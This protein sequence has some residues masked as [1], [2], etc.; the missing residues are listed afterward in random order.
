MTSRV[1][2]ASP[3]HDLAGSG[4]ALKAAFDAAPDW[5]ARAICRAQTYLRYPTDIVWRPHGGSQRREIA[6][7][8]HSADVVQAMNHPR[9]LAWFRPAQSQ[10]LV[11]HHLG[12]TFRRNPRAISA[13]CRRYGATEV[14][15]SIDLLFDGIGWLP[16]PA[17]LERLAALRAT[18]YRPSSTIRIAHAPTNR[19][20]KDTAAIVRAVES[21][22]R[23]YPISFDLIE[24]VPNAVCLK[25]KASAD[26]FIDQLRYGFGLNAIECWAMGI[27]V[28]SGLTDLTALNRGQ[29]MWGHLP[30]AN[31][32][33][34]TL[35]AVIEHLIVDEAWRQE[36]GERGRI[37]ADRWHSQSAVVE[38]ATALYGLPVEAAA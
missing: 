8:M 1:V 20:V 5:E 18:T 15:D 37:H 31:A 9:A 14:T 7:I 3:S 10:R 19:Q 16:I 32:R 23:K 36:L 35:E 25:R 29:A 34:E 13:L 26:I 21:L 24:R 30:W 33:A 11:V 22:S 4:Y 27:P 38:M 17:D 28:V 2:F 6:A 12:S